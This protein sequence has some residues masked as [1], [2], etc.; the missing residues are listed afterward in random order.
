MG[1]F[2]IIQFIELSLENVCGLHRC[3]QEVALWGGALW[4]LFLSGISLATNNTIYIMY[5]LQQKLSLRCNN[6][7]CLQQINNR[8]VIIIIRYVHV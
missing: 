6:I 8:L 3:V 4:P 2:K 5:Q 1:W 7:F